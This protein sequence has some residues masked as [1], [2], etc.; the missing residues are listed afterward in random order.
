MWVGFV[1]NI[2]VVG[3]AYCFPTFVDDSLKRVA[4]GVCGFRVDP[5]RKQ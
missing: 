2:A 4:S 1:E 3:W 5:D